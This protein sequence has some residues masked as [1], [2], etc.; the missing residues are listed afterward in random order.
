MREPAIRLLNSAGT[1]QTGQSANITVR[2]S[3]FATPANL[4]TCT[5]TE[6]GT[7]GNYVLTGFTDW[8]QQCKIYLSGVE[9]TA[10]GTQS[11]GDLAYEFIDNHTAQTKAGVLTFT[12][13]P[14]SS[15][16]AAATTELVRFD[17][18]ILTTGNQGASGNK[19]F[20]GIVTLGNG[21]SAGLPVLFPV[22]ETSDPPVLTQNSQVVAKKH[23]D[24]A[25][26]AVTT[27]A[28]QESARKVRVFPDGTEVTDQVYLT[29]LTG[30]DS[31]ATPT[32]TNLCVVEIAG[33]AAAAYISGAVG[34]LK[35]YVTL[36]GSG[37]HIQL[38]LLDITKTAVARLED[39]T[40]LMGQGAGNGARSY[41]SMIFENCIIYHY[42]NVTLTNCNVRNCLFLGSSSYAVTVDGSTKVINS[43]FNNAL[44]DG[45]SFTGIKVNVTDGF[46]YAPPSDPTTGT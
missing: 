30:V 2:E 31:F 36:K 5:V 1:P 20:T 40:V 45:D 3:P 22:G 27:S 37:K 38:Y 29:V 12:S 4:V 9:Q 8:Y 43:Q 6:V 42:H 35:D 15:T 24:D 10:C 13:A 28:F 41:N 39:L 46:T 23:L 16:A 21:T 34:S 19:G 17:E 25:V 26:A 7:Q 44:V 33:M 11:M 32:A 14:K 18:A